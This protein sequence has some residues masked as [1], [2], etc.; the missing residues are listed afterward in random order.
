MVENCDAD[1]MRFASRSDFASHLRE[2][3]HAKLWKCN[4]CGY[5]NGERHLVE[6]HIASTHTIPKDAP[7][8]HG[9]SERSVLRDLS[10][11]K[12][13]FCDKTPGANVFV[14]HICHHL[15]EISLAAIPRNGETDDEGASSSSEYLTSR[16]TESIEMSSPKPLAN[17]TVDED[18]PYTIKCICGFA[19]DDGNTIWCETC[20][21][22]QHIECY[23]P[24]RV[25]DASREDFE[26][27]CL[28]CK[29]RM[30]MAPEQAK[31]RDIARELA[32]SPDLLDPQLSG[33]I[34]PVGMHS[35]AGGKAKVFTDVKWL[36]TKLSAIEPDCEEL[37]A[38]EREETQD[39][40]HKSTLGLFNSQREEDLSYTP[41][42]D[43]QAIVMR[44]RGIS[45]TSPA[46][47][48][49]GTESPS[50]DKSCK[51]CG[52]NSARFDLHEAL[53]YGSY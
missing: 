7:F 29:P 10:N 19:E 41:G 31:E 43:E 23:Y 13:P 16:S 9:I 4:F 45:L 20:D 28:D 40:F 53:F 11:Q 32:H 48:G 52:K 5:E 14:G 51:M 44:H 34:T 47:Q 46:N 6:A 33:N 25:G 50:V 36:D 21:T 2:H 42:L 17:F 12:C 27:S 18:E 1:C 39:L 26:H 49:R 37:A 30:M 22:W 38:D 8:S 35:E 3:Q 15:E 24:G